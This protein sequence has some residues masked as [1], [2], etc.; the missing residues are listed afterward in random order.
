[1]NVYSK[2]VP[3]VFLAKCTEKQQQLFKQMY[4]FENMDKDINYAVDNMNA[5]KLDW[6]M[7]Q[8]NRTLN[9]PTN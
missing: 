4:A 9:P 1:M 6:A 8:L 7:T 2:Y 5:E 3:N